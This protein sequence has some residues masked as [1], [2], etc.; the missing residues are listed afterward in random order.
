[1]LDARSFTPSWA[2]ACHIKTSDLGDVWQ[3]ETDPRNERGE[4]CIGYFDVDDRDPE[5]APIVEL[6]GLEVEG[7]E[8]RCFYDAEDAACLLGQDAIARV[9]RC[10]SDNPHDLEDA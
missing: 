3:E 5:S 8:G 2:I 7:A 10:L 4:T 6:L 1:M 9:E